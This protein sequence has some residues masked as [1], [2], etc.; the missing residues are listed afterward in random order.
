MSTHT[1]NC[2]K[3]S[4]QL[5][6]YIISKTCLEIVNVSRIH[7]IVMIF[8]WS[9]CDGTDSQNVLS[10]GIP[11]NEK[12]LAPY[13]D[14]YQTEVARSTTDVAAGT[15]IICSVVPSEP[16]RCMKCCS[17]F[18]WSVKSKLQIHNLKRNWHHNFPAVY[19]GI[20]LGWSSI[21]G[22]VKGLDIYVC[23]NR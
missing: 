12:L 2:Q 17:P 7:L 10:N 18:P 22:V 11:Y 9:P 14:S 20:H 5:N 13:R 6:C 1:F 21:K 23:E 4:D 19:S 16:A 3:N 15:K 8:M